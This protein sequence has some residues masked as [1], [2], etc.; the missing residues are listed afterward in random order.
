MFDLL[1]IS[2][3]YYTR[4][5]THI[6]VI[7][8]IPILNRE[9]STLR[10]YIPVPFLE[11]NET[12][13]FN[14]NAKFV[15]VQNETLEMISKENLKLCLNINELTICNSLMTEIMDSVDP[16]IHSFFLG[17]YVECQNKAIEPHNYIIDTSGNSVYC[18]ILRPFGL[19][20]SCYDGD[21]ILNLTE[22]QE[23]HFEDHCE[24]Y[25][26]SRDI[27]YNASTYTT[28][29]I[30]HSYIP[31]NLSVFSANSENIT[32]DLFI[33]DRFEIE[34]LQIYQSTKRMQEDSGKEEKVES[35][36]IFSAFFEKVKGYSESFSY[37]MSY[38]FSVSSPLYWVFIPLLIVIA[39][40]MW[41]RRH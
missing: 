28:I 7:V 23:I 11:N 37:A 40:T 32:D 19:K 16:C 26:I 27:S 9:H 25:K 35:E 20:I 39:I 10:A 38:I 15:F 6:K 12:K 2:S 5:S 36:T 31:S 3:V 8:E 29:N 14:T 1:R 33:V 13:I 34:L 21:R 41:C 22:N 17:N 24:I 18:F 4:N 30:T